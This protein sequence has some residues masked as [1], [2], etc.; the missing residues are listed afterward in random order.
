MD[1]GKVLRKYDLIKRVFDVTVSSVLAIVLAPVA[2]GVA[3]AVAVKLG[4]PILFKQ[5]RPGLHGETFHML[6]FRTMLEP[7]ISRGWVTDAQR[8]TPL[9]R[10]LRSTS[11]DELPAIINV[12]K[13]EMSLVGPRPLL[14]S[15]L[16]LYSAEQSRRHEVRPGITGLAQVKGRNSVNWDERFRLDV[17]YVDRRSFWLDLRILALTVF[18]VLKRDGITEPGQETMSAFKGSYVAHPDGDRDE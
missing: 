10:K 14:V 9:G 15:Y 3:V 11:L 8:L 18:T 12:L 17:D 16:E 2:A 6:K 5:E 13:G 7:N 1:C 4:R